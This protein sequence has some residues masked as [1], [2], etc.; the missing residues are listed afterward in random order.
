MK[1]V[2][3]IVLRENDQKGE[4]NGR[5]P[6]LPPRVYCTMTLFKSTCEGFNVLHTPH[7][8]HLP[9]KL[10]LLSLGPRAKKSA[11]VQDVTGKGV[12][13]TKFRHMRS[14]VRSRDRA[15]NKIVVDHIYF[16]TRT[17]SDMLLVLCEGGNDYDIIPGRRHWAHY[18]RSPRAQAEIVS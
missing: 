15:W 14:Y 11:P 2:I 5:P 4:N 9:P 17:R 18:L 10:A 1:S 16:A 8:D 3:F 12:G 6:P 13:F 7:G